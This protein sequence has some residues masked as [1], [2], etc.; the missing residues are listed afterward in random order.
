CVIF[1]YCC[2]FFQAED[3]IRDRNVTG[4]QTCA[5]PI[6]LRTLSS[7]NFYINMFHL[8]SLFFLNSPPT[9][10]PAIP[11]NIAPDTV[12][13]FTLFPVCGNFSSISL[14]VLFCLNDCILP[15]S[16]ELRLGTE[17]KS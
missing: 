9:I 11:N 4:V 10:I 2:F 7:H 3:G 5:L 16:E 15:R 12:R 6:F 17:C 14:C 13:L 8:S 1:H